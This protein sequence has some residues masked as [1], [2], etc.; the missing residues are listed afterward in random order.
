MDGTGAT[1]IISDPAMT[2]NVGVHDPTDTVF[3]ELRDGTQVD[4]VRY[5]FDG[6]NTGDGFIVAV[7][8]GTPPDLSWAILQKEALM[9]LL[10]ETEGANASV[11]QRDIDGSNPQSIGPTSTMDSGQYLTAAAPLN[12]P[13]NTAPEYQQKESLE[14]QA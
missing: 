4:Y 2:R 13:A 9:I 7:S 3:A 6:T 12:L 5:N 11:Q 10:Q 1:T 8:S 14:Y